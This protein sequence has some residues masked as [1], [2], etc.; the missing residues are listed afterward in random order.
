MTNWWKED[1][2]RQEPQ[3]CSEVSVVWAECLSSYWN[4]WAIVLEEHLLDGFNWDSKGSLLLGV[5]LNVSTSHCVLQFRSE[6]AQLTGVP[7]LHLCRNLSCQ[8]RYGLRGVHCL[9]CDFF[10]HICFLQHS[11]WHSTFN[12]YLF[13]L[14]LGDQIPKSQQF[15]LT[16]CSKFSIAL[17]F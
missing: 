15:N 14:F 13:P 5:T 12:F 4:T 6:N 7:L 9:P 2:Q 3:M 1:V 10:G 16:R 17:K 8:L 11:T